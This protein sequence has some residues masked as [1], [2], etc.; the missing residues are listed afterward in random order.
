ML[1]INTAF[2]QA[3]L[4]L[5]TPDG[6]E[7]FCDLDANTKHSENVLRLIDKL[8]Q[9]AKIDVLDV[10]D[11]SI[12][13]GPGSFTGLRI[14]AAIAKALACVNKNLRLIPMSSLE[15]MAY[16]HCK[17]AKVPGDFVCALNALS[18]LYFVAYFDKNGIKLKEAQLVKGEEFEKIA[19]QK[20]ILKGDLS[21]KEVRNCAEVEITGKTLL[22]FAQKLA[23]EGVCCDVGQLN[24]TYLRLSQ[25]ED[26]LLKKNENFPQ[27]S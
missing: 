15:L 12:V 11:V 13:I 5:S 18:N 25:A 9:D 14:G 24:P 6:R 16:I 23:A 7:F 22:E 10:Q 4:A 2:M 17:Q 21:P 27:N 3:N 26:Q 1:V 19:C 8:C 20:V